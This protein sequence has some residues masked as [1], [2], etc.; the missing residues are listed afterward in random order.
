MRSGQRT[1][2]EFML[3]AFYALIG[4]FILLMIALNFAD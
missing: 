3:F 1:S 4:M 2:A